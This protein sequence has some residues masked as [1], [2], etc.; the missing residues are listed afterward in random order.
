M[1]VDFQ[2]FL[3]LSQKKKILNWQMFIGLESFWKGCVVM[4][5]GEI[6]FV[7]FTGTFLFSG[8]VL[9]VL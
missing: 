5:G 2:L 8:Q 4:A 9:E 7:Y 1:F 3:L 6:L